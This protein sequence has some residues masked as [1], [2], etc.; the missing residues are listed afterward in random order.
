MR[1]TGFAGIVL[2]LLA[3]SANAQEAV[4]IKEGRPNVGDRVRVTKTDS[5]KTVVTV[6]VGGKTSTKDDPESK[7]IVYTDE[8]LAVGEGM[9]KPLKL[10]RTYEKYEVAKGGKVLPGPPLNTAIVIEK[11]ES[12]YT[13][14][15]EGKT[16]DAAFVATLTKEFEE[17]ANDPG[18]KEL[19][20]DK[21]V[22][23]GDTWK[24]DLSKVGWLSGKDAKL[25]ADL[26]KSEL[27]GKLVKAYKK[28]GKQFGVLEFTGSVTIKSLGEKSPV[29]VKP[30]S[31][32]TF[33]MSGEG[34]IDGTAPSG[35]MTTLIEGTINGDVG[36]NSL[37]VTMK[38]TNNSVSELLP[39]K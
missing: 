4:T 39:K 34:C 10:K 31:I 27:T 33:K 15:A 5:M 6:T 3:V 35:K 16:L 28:D 9:R 2:G 22:K 8:V 12:K 36:E 24:V 20:P 38:G 1:Q 37:V 29:M 23:P 30:G 17:D 13:Y 32:M 19:F 25:A 14:N 11:K 18:A 21:P 26:E 7:S